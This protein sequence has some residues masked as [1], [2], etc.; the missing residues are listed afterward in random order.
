MSAGDHGC[1]CPKVLREVLG[2]VGSRMRDLAVRF[3]DQ[4]DECQATHCA[5]SVSVIREILNLSANCPDHVE[6]PEPDAEVKRLNAALD[7]IVRQLHF[8]HSGDKQRYTRE[9][10]ALHIAKCARA[11]H[12]YEELT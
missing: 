5:E 4:D 1:G 10:N 7:S 3:Q 9:G 12:G 8:L 6:P 2:R 11:G